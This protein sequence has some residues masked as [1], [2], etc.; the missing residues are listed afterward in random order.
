[1]LVGSNMLGLTHLANFFVVF[2][3]RTFSAAFV[4]LTPP[5]GGLASRPNILFGTGGL[6]ASPS[7]PTLRRAGNVTHMRQSRMLS[8]LRQI[9]ARKI[10][11]ALTLIA[12]FCVAQ[13]AFAQNDE[14]SF[15]V[16]PPL[17]QVALQPGE[18]WSTNIQVVNG[19]P[20]NLAVYAEPTL[21]E[22]SGEEG[23]VTFLFPGTSNTPET[24]SAGTLVDW[25][26]VPQGALDIPGEQT[27]EVPL[28]ISIPV[29]AAPGGHSAA[30]LIGNRSPE[31]VRDENQVAVTSSIASLIFVTVAGDVIEK[32][33]IR[34]FATERTIYDTAEARFSLRFENQGNVHLQPQGDITIYN[35][36]GKVRGR[37]TVNQKS[38]FGNVLPESV[39]KFSFSWK[40]DVGTW[41]I[42]RY[43]AEATLGYGNDSKQFALATT[44]FY[45][46][47]IVP[48][49]EFVGG[50]LVL[51]IF[52]GWAIRAYI[53]RA[54]YLETARLQ[55]TQASAGG[56][57]LQQPL[58]TPVSLTVKPAIELQTLLRPIQAGMVDLRSVT[59]RKVSTESAPV[60][61]RTRLSV[62]DF[63]FKYRYF[64]GFFLVAGSAWFIAGFVFKDVLTYE[65]PYEVEVVRDAP[66]GAAT[67]TDGQ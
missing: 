67:S 58:E 57:P 23:R 40:S 37:I 15:T 55:Y 66:E 26:T 17:I 16:V 20:Y 30:I 53:R 47:P 10:A 50:A 25:I 29:D 21:I 31:G 5:V 8:V 2:V 28:T 56:A 63:I 45:Y 33:R 1:M 11:C 32:G 35:M 12:L 39:R 62:G 18:T 60:P 27:R 49:I 41:D 46:L 54:L 4:R 59:A 61:S 51:L 24:N 9:R 48:L 6:D 36:F 43:R 13:T 19:N 44:Y 52:F 42:G 65:R 7:A 14:L 34:D 3:T 38:H 64:L 22:P